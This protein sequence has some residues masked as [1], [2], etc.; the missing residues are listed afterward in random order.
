[1]AAMPAI[2]SELTEQQHEFVRLMV[3]EG[4]SPEEAGR[5]AGYHPKSVYRTMRHP[6]V[7]AA[8]SEAI[9]LDLRSVGAALA[10]RVAKSLLKDE[11]VSARV[12]ADLSIK[13]L[14]RAGH[15]TPSRKD[16]EPQ[17]KAL[18]EMSQEELVAFIERNQAEIDKVESELASRATDVSFLA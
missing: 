3:V 7:A 5:L 13:V 11:K 12:R 14:D 6:L 2:T 15:V 4:H 16:L 10:Y 9:Q 8:I 18:S 17:R 1:M